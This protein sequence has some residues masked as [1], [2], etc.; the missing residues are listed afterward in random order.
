MVI[1]HNHDDHT[2]GLIALRRELMQKN[3]RAMSRAHVSANI[4]L[5]RLKVDGSDDNGLTPPRAQYERLG[6]R[7]TLRCRC[8]CRG[9]TLRQ[10]GVQRG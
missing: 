10:I 5:P 1:S 6:G 8:R 4:F 3:P 2:G 9:N 7:F